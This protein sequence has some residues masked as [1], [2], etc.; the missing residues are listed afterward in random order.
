MQFLTQNAELKEVSFGTLFVSNRALLRLIFST[1][2]S[3]I[4]VRCRNIMVLCRK[5]LG[6]NILSHRAVETL[7][8]FFYSLQNFKLFLLMS[9]LNQGDLIDRCYRHWK[10]K[11]SVSGLGFRR[12]FLVRC[13]N[14][15]RTVFLENPCCVCL[16]LS[17]RETSCSAA[18]K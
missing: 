18:S 7:N 14:F 16:D 13:R 5:T 9:Y 17:T 4:M 11:N 8:F 15:L 1:E 12:I 2:V 3:Q 10:L 6:V